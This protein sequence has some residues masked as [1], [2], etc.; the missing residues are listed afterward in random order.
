MLSSSQLLFDNE[1][2]VHQVTISN[3]GSTLRR[4][5]LIEVIGFR[6]RRL[7]KRTSKEQIIQEVILLSLYFCRIL[8]LLNIA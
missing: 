5:H 3:G 8:S 1:Q 2:Q 4:L 7:K 6:M